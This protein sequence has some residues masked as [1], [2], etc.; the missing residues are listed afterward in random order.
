MDPRN[1][2]PTC[3]ALARMD[4]ALV[5]LQAGLAMALEALRTPEPADT[6]DKQPTSQ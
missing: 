6:D 4:R 1:Y 3:V 2:I 5:E